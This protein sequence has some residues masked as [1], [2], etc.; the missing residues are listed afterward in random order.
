MGEN[1][2]SKLV[3]VLNNL[4]LS[5]LKEAVEATDGVELSDIL[6]ILDEETS[7]LEEVL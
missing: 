4:R 2:V 5:E 6:S 1:R 3:K 7:L